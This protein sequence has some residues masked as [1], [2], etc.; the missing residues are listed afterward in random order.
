MRRDGRNQGIAHWLHALGGLLLAATVVV[1][2][3]GSL[4]LLL[5]PSR[6]PAEAGSSGVPGSL[7]AGMVLTAAVAAGVA[8]STRQT[9]RRRNLTL[10]LLAAAGA[11]YI[12]QIVRIGWR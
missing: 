8:A 1:G 10:Y 4:Y 2:A 6:T 3:G 12:V 7:V 5:D 11:Y 9:A